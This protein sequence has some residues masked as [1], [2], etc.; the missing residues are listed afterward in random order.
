MPVATAAPPAPAPEPDAAPASVSL[1]ST[2]PDPL[3]E[4]TPSRVLGDVARPVELPE[5]FNERADELLAHHI[6]R[7]AQKAERR[8]LHV[9][10]VAARADAS[11][12]AAS[13]IDA[14]R[15]LRMP[16][17]SALAGIPSASNDARRLSDA[18]AAAFWN[19]RGAQR[20]LSLQLRA[21]GANP[22]DPEVA[23]NLAYYYLKQRPAQSE[24]ARQL[25]MYA[26]TL[27]DSRFPNGRLEDWTTLAIASALA[28]RPRDAGNAWFVTLA[29]LPN[30]DR[31][32]RAAHAAYASH[33][34]RLREPI[35]AMLS[36]ISAWGK[37]Q[38]STFCRWPPSWSARARI[39]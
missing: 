5:D 35:E 31:S 33:G 1:A 36:R 24:L 16:P 3:L 14:T 32:C 10:H 39:E 29:L 21:F 7:V 12:Q 23:G 4:S 25:A 34:E 37:S 2:I 22:E 15:T 26:L 27:N 20:A 13:V 38:E 6:P 19:G 11:W 30:P 18:A 17:D 9:L 28:G 8:V